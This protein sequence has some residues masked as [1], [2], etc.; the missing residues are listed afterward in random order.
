MN[1]S[2]SLLQGMNSTELEKLL[3]LAQARG[4]GKKDQRQEKIPAIP[5]TGPLPLSFSQRGMWMLSQNQKA[6]AVYNIAAAL[7]LVGSLNLDALRRSLDALLARHEALRSVFDAVDGEPQA[8]LL[9]D[10]TPMPMIEH[11]FRGQDDAHGM[12]ARLGKQEAAQPFDLVNGPLVRCRLVRMDEREHVLLL[13][14]HH[15][16]FD[17]WSAGILARELHALYEAFAR[18][19]ENPLQALSIQFPDYAAWQHSWLSGERLQR[20]TE[21]WRNALADAPALL[22]LPTDRPRPAV[23]DFVGS[24]VSL[25]LDAE[26]T[27]ALKHLSQTHGTTL[28]MTLLTGWSVVLSRLSGQGDVVIG[29]PTANRDRPE[30]QGL[31]GFFVNTLALRLN[32]AGA[33]DVRDLLEHVR[34]VLAGAQEHRDL[35]FDQVMEIVQPPRR[36]NHTPI[37]QVLCNWDDAHPM[38]APSSEI[39][40]TPVPMDYEVS[41]YDLKLNLAERDGRVQAELIYS[42][43]LFDAPTIE[44]HAVYLVNVLRAMAANAQQPVSRIGLMPAEEH[45]L[46]VQEWNATAVAYPHERCIHQLFEDQ[47]ERTPTALALAHGE[48]TMDYARLNAQANRLAHCLIA[49]GVRPDHRV[50]ICVERSMAMVVGM[51]AILK[52]GAAYVPLDP[53]YSSERLAQVLTD[54]APMLVLHDA[55]GRSA[56]GDAALSGHACLDLEPLHADGAGSGAWATCPADNPCVPGLSS[57]QL[58]YVIYTSGSTGTPKGVMVE[59]HSVVNFE[60]AMRRHIYRGEHALRIGWNASFSFDMSMKGFLQLLA[61]HTLVIIPQEVRTSARDLVAFLDEQAIDGFDVTPSQLRG[62]LAEG[63]LAQARRRTVLIGGEAIDADLWEQLKRAD[64][65]EFHN[66]YGPTECTVDATMSIIGPDDAVPH[67]GR[68]FDNMRIYLLDQAGQPVPR[69]AAGEIYI[70][71][72][73]VA[74]GYLN[75]PE[76][77]AERFMADPFAAEPQARMYRTGDLGRY[78]PDGRLVYLGRNDRQVK[79]RGFRIELGEIEAHLAALEPVREAVVLAR[80]VGEEAVEQRLVAYVVPHDAGIDSAGLIETLRA[81]L[82]A[83]LPDYMVPP[84]FVRLDA[85]PLTS[86]GKLDR[87]ALPAPDDEAYAVRAYEAPQGEVEQ[88]MAGLWQELLQCGRVGREDDFFELGGHSL[89]AVR[90]MLHIRQTFG[91]ELPVV[92]LFSHPTLAGLSQAVVAAGGGA[93]APALPQIAVVPR[94]GTLPLSFA[95]QRLWFLAQW[96]GVSE[97]YHIP[98]LLRLRGSLDRAALQRSLDTLMQRHEALRSVFEPV[99]GQPQVRLL[100]A[101]TALPMVEHDLSD[102]LEVSPRLRQLTLEEAS[103]PF[104]LRRGPLIRACLIRLAPDHHVLVLTQHHIVSDGWSIGVISRE[105]GTLYQAFVQGNPH[106]LPPLSIQYPDYA[107]WQRDWLSG[108][109]VTRQADYWRSTLA[110]APA[111]LE[112]PTDRPRPQQQDFTGAQVPVAFDAE[113]TRAVKRLSQQ[114]GVTVFMTLLAAWTVVLSR[115]SGQNDVVVGTPTANRSH[116]QTEDLVGFFV[117]TLALRVDLEGVPSAR[118][119]L[120]RVRA[121]SLA[122]QDHQDLPFEQIVELLQPKRRL[123]HTPIFQVLLNWHNND[124]SAPAF[125]DMQVDLLETD[126][127]AVKF[128]LELNLAEFDDQISGALSYASALFEPATMRRHV[129]YLETVLRAMVLDNER[130]LAAIDI[131]TRQERAMLQAWNDTG[132]PYRQ[133]CCAHHL[134]E[135][136]VRKTPSAPAVRFEGKTLSYSELNAQANRLAH[137]LID[138]GVRRGDRV[139]ICVERSA[140]MVAGVLA[141][142]KA[143]GAYVPLD[144]AYPSE[145]LGQVLADAA[146]VA[147]LSDAAGR[148]ALGAAAGAWSLVDLEPLRAGDEEAG[149]WSGCPGTDPQV[150]GLT[151][152]HLAYVIYTSGSTGKPKGVM[153]MHKPLIN[154]IEWLNRRFGV[155]PD[156]VVLL[157][158]SLSFD[159]SVYDIFGLLAAGGCVHVASRAE[160]ADPQR[161]ARMLF[162]EKLTFWDSAPAVFQQLLFF[163][164]EAGVPG[165]SQ[166]RL[167][168]FSGDWIPLEFFGAIKRAFPACEMIGLGGA[169]EATVWSNFYPVT[170]IDPKWASIP[171]GRPIQNARYYVLDSYLNPLPIGSRGDLYIGGECLTAGYF[172]R[173]D[174]SAERFVPDPFAVVPHGRMY[175]TGDQARYY[176]DGNLEFLGRIDFQVKIRGFRIELG[177]VEARLAESPLVRDSV[178]VARPDASGEKR[179]LAYVVPTDADTGAAELASALRATMMARLPDYMVP[180]AFVRMDALPLTPNGKLDRDQLPAPQGDAFAQ[181]SYAAPEGDVEQVIARVWQELLGVEQVGRYDNFF[182]LGGHSLLAVRLMERLR[183]ENLHMD[184]RALFVAPVLRE[185]ALQTNELEEI[186]L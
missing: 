99:D 154:L 169:T 70:G 158:S 145:R 146:P 42:T 173:E 46:L 140:A 179:L 56:I 149:A 110:G 118:E 76:L 51:L 141:V 155:G 34:S 53:T 14:Q 71:G 88:A 10:T 32:P 18:G 26:L 66:M 83:R 64:T 131:V 38:P 124:Q 12:L 95:Q 68:P 63:L 91:A 100:P 170:H 165:Q 81:E 172:G 45:R 104:D 3:K 60:Q 152:D 185:F 6:S 109:R 75:R 82:G 161:L 98:T 89:L 132:T 33:G 78:L 58:A 114:H 176:A 54:A 111:L 92:T 102:V 139:A 101:D 164:D 160:V 50:A 117:N 94:D 143:G 57:R 184:V 55:R 35:P 159:L 148:E 178:V 36:R 17:G 105:L 44:R 11:D 167:A 177:E 79:I 128:D 127:Q 52:A 90:L 24:Q 19:Q 77:T 15:I 156:D 122:A 121:V 65:V 39:D 8:R 22:E 106:G 134:F 67:I 40:V 183:Q 175:K 174:L 48:R 93:A 130:P 147:M 61:G 21:Y 87:K 23:Q 181:R 96:E 129:E 115:L 31:I 182:E 133:D 112:L 2:N 153:G 5:R 120:A 180:S 41:H 135:E 13:T 142:V 72:A 150:A 171:Y 162:T 116:V 138:L 69:G 86:N 29:M 7:R 47:A 1:T 4:I 49:Q 144:P 166:L 157:T 123:D 126:Y 97:T 85:L 80:D 16:V 163:L 43:A 28:F 186:R 168:F 108:D 74:R 151:P 37:F 137:H 103:A 25:E 20:Q 84:A 59:H 9:P 125:P 113:L 119:L 27:R 73:G 107:A 30:L 136:Q 62:L